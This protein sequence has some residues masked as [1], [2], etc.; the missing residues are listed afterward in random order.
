MISEIQWL[1][2]NPNPYSP[3]HT[4]E[5][6]DGRVGWKLHAVQTTAQ[7]KFSELRGKK[8]ACGLVPKHGWGLD[9]FIDD[10][11]KCSR[12]LM[13]LGIGCPACKG[14]G[15]KDGQPCSECF[16]TGIKAERETKP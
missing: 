11:A 8:A 15:W 10:N 2:T 14:K 9:M 4:C 5:A 3:A 12:C 6:D 1:T 7:N 16:C 13:A